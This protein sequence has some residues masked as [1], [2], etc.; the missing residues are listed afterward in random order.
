MITENRNKIKIAVGFVE[1]QTGDVVL[2]WATN[3]FTTGPDSFYK[4]LNRAGVQP[5]DAIHTFKAN[6]RSGGF[7]EGDCLSTIA[8]MLNFKI[9]IHSLLPT[10]RDYNLNWANIMHTIKAYKTDNVC[11]SVYI[12]IPDWSDRIDFIAN[13]FG[14]D[15]MFENME[16]IFI[17][18]DE[19]EK[20]LLETTITSL[21]E[22][23][24]EPFIN[25]VDRFLKKLVVKISPQSSSL[26]LFKNGNNKKKLQEDVKRT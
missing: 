20:M 23:K 13:F 6:I 10:S 9:M 14:Y 21:Y 25:K 18:N 12:P 3:S 19:R 7:K 22:F 24:K 11:R 15:E 2:N 17:V 1:M 26:L 5:L 8:G 16:Y 4:L